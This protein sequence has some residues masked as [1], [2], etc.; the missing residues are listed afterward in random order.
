M[1]HWPINLPLPSQSYNSTASGRLVV[2]TFETGFRQ[3]RRYSYNE[4]LLRVTWLMTQL[5]FDVFKAFVKLTLSNGANA[6]YTQIVG[7]DGIEYAEVY[8]KDGAF[9]A[10]YTPH[11]MQTVSAEL[12]RVN[13]TVMDANTL[14]ILIMPEMLD[15]DNFV[16]M[17]DALEAYNEQALR[18]SQSTEITRNFMSQFNL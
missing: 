14:E 16:F 3:R 9:T 2:N 5:E 11:A 4:D 18:N 7:L 15:P 12:V 6:F 8:L 13:P 1:I 10:T 17:S